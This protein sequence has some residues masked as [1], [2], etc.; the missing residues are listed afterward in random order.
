VAPRLVLVRVRRRRH[1]GLA[2]FPALSQLRSE[3]M[4]LTRGR[5][6]RGDGIGHAFTIG[7]IKKTFHS[8]WMTCFSR[9]Q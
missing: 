4:L 1:G 8:Q 9:G 7:N 2:P 5:E 6:D 3:L